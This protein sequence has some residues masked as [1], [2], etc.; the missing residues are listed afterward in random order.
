MRGSIQV[1]G[2]IGGR[3]KIA[4][5]VASCKILF[6]IPDVTK[7]RVRM[8]NLAEDQVKYSRKLDSIS[9]CYPVGPSS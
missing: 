9:A 4:V 6:S 7:R 3:K 5:M 2:R 8:M 1:V